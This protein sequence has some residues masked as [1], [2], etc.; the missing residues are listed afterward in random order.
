MKRKVMF[1]ILMTALMFNAFGCGK[2]ET[3]KVPTTEDPYEAPDVQGYTS[4][5]NKF[6]DN[7]QTGW[8]LDK[9]YNEDI[10][11]ATLNNKIYY[12][13]IPESNKDDT[14][15]LDR[16]N[17]LCTDST[18]HK[19]DN[20][21]GITVK[22]TDTSCVYNFK[23]GDTL[24]DIRNDA[25][26]ELA[27]DDNQ[28][29]LSN[30]NS[31]VLPIMSKA[32]MKKITNGETCRFLELTSPFKVSSS[33]GNYI[34][35]K[36]N[37]SMFDISIDNISIESGN[38]YNDRMSFGNGTLYGKQLQDFGIDA[39]LNV[40]GVDFNYNTTISD[41]VDTWGLPKNCN[42]DKYDE[43]NEYIA[44]M[45]WIDTSGNIICVKSKIYGDKVDG[46]DAYNTSNI[47]GL[48]LYSKDS[49]KDIMNFKGDSL[50]SFLNNT[51]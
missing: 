13:Y 20:S 31:T 29:T 28:L 32:T 37:T 8:R 23:L 2:T 16:I 19:V 5:N 40:Y 24:R 12:K 50:N 48:Y 1:T 3:E 33:L 49:A 6:N 47:T 36:N 43:E 46:C 18:I 14:L 41:I 27:N 45:L 15:L 51:L 34:K 7:M 39:T 11:D 4:Y 25:I 38:N 9:F 44:S 22:S 17:I 21:K 35:N 30:T 26:Q 42:I 10:N